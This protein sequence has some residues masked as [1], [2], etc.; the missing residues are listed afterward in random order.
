MSNKESASI[1]EVRAGF[2]RQGTSLTAFCREQ[3]LDRRHVHSAL[4]G[5]WT[6]PTA[7]KVAAR[8][9]AASRGDDA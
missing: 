9:A 6:G 8:V 2:V 4:S 3:G 7:S 5:R 1:Q